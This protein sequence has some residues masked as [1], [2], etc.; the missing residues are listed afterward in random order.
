MENVLKFEYENG[1]QKVYPANRMVKNWEFEEDEK[2]EA[3]LAHTMAVIAEKNGIG[4][5]DLQHLFPAVLRMLK[6]DIA[7]SK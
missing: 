7:W 2:D 6:S 5:Y 4:S 3:T 1:V